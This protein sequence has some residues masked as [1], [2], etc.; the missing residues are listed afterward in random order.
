MAET[1][2][3]KLKVKTVLKKLLKEKGLNINKIV[4]FG[5]FARG[6]QKEDSDIDIIIISSDFRDKG[7]FER[8]KLTT[9]IGR[10]L[11]RKVKMP[12]DL[13]YYSDEEW[14][15]KNFLIINEAKA[16]GEIIYG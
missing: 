15:N 9:G 16:Y 10:E 4:M 13:L 2:I 1:D 3:I 14:E 5:S 11:V 6:E 8:V 7:I 12:F